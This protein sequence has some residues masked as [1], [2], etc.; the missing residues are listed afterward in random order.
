MV[1]SDTFSREEINKIDPFL[2]NK[3]TTWT[4]PRVAGPVRKIERSKIEPILTK[5]YFGVV[6]RHRNL[7]IYYSEDS[8]VISISKSNCNVITKMHLII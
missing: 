1:R 5:Y 7:N 2:V 8:R 3:V 4:D 6:H